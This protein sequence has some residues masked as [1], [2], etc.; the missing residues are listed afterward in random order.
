MLM[1]TL[2]HSSTII[3]YLSMPNT[4]KKK[5]LKNVFASLSLNFESFGFE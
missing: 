3:D 5:V 1:R 4:T 2:T